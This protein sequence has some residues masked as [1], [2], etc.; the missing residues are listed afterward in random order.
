MVSNAELEELYVSQELSTR[1][2]GKI[3]G[4]NHVMVLKWLKF[5][6]IP[7]RDRFSAIRLRLHRAA[8]PKTELADLY[9]N[10]RLKIREL[11]Q[12][13]RTND[14]IVRKWLVSYGIPLRDKNDNLKTE[15]SD[16][17]RQHLSQKRKE[18][19]SNPKNLEAHL[20]A[21]QTEKRR[22]R[23]AKA[24][25]ESW[26]DPEKRAKR[27]S[28][29]LKASF[30]RPTQPEQ[31]LIDLIAKYNLPYRYTGDG[32]F[33]VAGLNPDFVEVNGRKLAVDVFGDYWHNI[34]QDEPARTE[35]GRKAIFADYGWEL[36]VL[37]E[38]EIN[39]LPEEELVAQLKK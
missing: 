26:Q 39:N 12:H 34:K 4:V 5:Y 38:H 16:N 29:M 36:V 3:L 31:R 22:E 33:I 14:R 15:W 20:K 6:D 18:F 37:W 23:A 25:R 32:S 2:I 27:M 9:L 7:L 10:K 17:E 28:N 19:L 13:Y 30:K 11:S 1:Q 35:Q 24:N 21:T 8:P